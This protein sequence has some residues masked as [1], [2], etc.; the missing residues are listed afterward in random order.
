M[1]LLFVVLALGLLILG[2]ARVSGEVNASAGDIR[3]VFG[4]LGMPIVV[5]LKQSG[6]RR[7]EFEWGTVVILAVPFL[8][9]QLWALWHL[10]RRR[11]ALT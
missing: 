1:T 2:V 5:G 9:G 7:L 8:L 11:A 4:I 3:A 6:H 10:M